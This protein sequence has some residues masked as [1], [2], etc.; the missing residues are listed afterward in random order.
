LRPFKVG[1]RF[2]EQ[3]RDRVRRASGRKLSLR[4]PLVKNSGVVKALVFVAQTLENGFRFVVAIG[5]TA[6]ELIGDRETEQT[7]RCLVF[8][9]SGEDIATDRFSFSG[10]VQVAI[11]FGLRD[12]FGN[13]VFRDR[14]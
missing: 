1:E 14:F 2:F 8:G 7:Q 11:K 13:A 4:L 10:L 3:W 12:R 6:A 9:I 5:G